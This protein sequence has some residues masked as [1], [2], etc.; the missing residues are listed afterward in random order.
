[1]ANNYAIHVD[2]ISARSVTLDIWGINPDLER[3]PHPNP[4]LPAFFLRLLVDHAGPAKPAVAALVPGDV[5]DAWLLAHAGEHVVDVTVTGTKNYPGSIDDMPGV[6]YRVRVTD[7]RW[8]AHLEANAAWDSA[9]HETID[10]D[11]LDGWSEPERRLL[12]IDEPPRRDGVVDQLCRALSLPDVDAAFGAVDALG[13][14]ADPRAASAL[15]VFL[16]TEKDRD[17]AAVALAL[18]RI[19]PPA[20]M[21]VDALR[22][23]AVPAHPLVA[24]VAGF[25]LHRITGDPSGLALLDAALTTVDDVY[26]VAQAIRSLGPAERT[27]M[28]PAVRRALAAGGPSSSELEVLLADLGG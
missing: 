9:A 11:A 4:A 27:A 7:P 21:A 24:G 26:H 17:R 16:G 1:M 22:R 23:L 6:S 14:L 12:G 19:G 18:G 15:T 5:D 8:L 10:P 2:A 28:E 20:E 13:K 3:W 25:A